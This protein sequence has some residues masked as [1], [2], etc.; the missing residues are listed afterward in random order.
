MQIETNG[1]LVPEATFVR[2]KAPLCYVLQVRVNA[3]RTAGEFDFCAY[4]YCCLLV[5]IV[6]LLWVRKTA[7]KSSIFTVI[8]SEKNND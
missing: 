6:T 7:R 8:V 1:L 2:T 3:T 4:V 5:M